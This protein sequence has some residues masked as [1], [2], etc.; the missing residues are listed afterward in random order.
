VSLSFLVTVRRYWL[1]GFKVG[2]RSTI[3]YRRGETFLLMRVANGFRPLWWTTNSFF[4]L[5]VGIF[6]TRFILWESFSYYEP[7][8]YNLFS[9]RR[10]EKTSYILESDVEGTAAVVKSSFESRYLFFIVFIHFLYSWT[11]LG[12]FFGTFI[13]QTFN[14]RE[15]SGNPFFF[16]RSLLK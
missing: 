9:P 5:R 6:I 16:L 15:F 1:Q 2:A 12:T 7:G 11:E 3:G 8:S 14:T 10:Q 4:P 13:N